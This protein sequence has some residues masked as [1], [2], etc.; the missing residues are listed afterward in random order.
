MIKN[1]NRKATV[2]RTT[3]S[4]KTQKK[5]SANLLLSLLLLPL[6]LL[7]LLVV[8]QNPLQKQEQFK[9]NAQLSSPTEWGEPVRL[10]RPIS[11]WGWDDMPFI[12]ASGDK[13]YLVSNPCGCGDTAG[14]P[15]Y[16]P[17]N[18]QIFA[19]Y[20]ANMGATSWE[21]PQLLDTTNINDPTF[22]V[23]AQYITPDEQTIYFSRVNW[24]V[25]KDNSLDLYV[26][27]KQPD[28]TWGPETRLPT[29]INTQVQED[30]P[31]L[32]LD[33]KELYFWRP[34]RVGGPKIYVSKRD[35]IN[36]DTC[37]GNPQAL[38]S[39][40]NSGFAWHPFIWYDGR[41]LYFARQ[42]RDPFSCGNTDHVGE[43]L[44]VS[45]RNDNGTWTDPQRLNFQRTAGSE[46]DPCVRQNYW[47][48]AGGPSVT[49]DGQSLYFVLARVN[50][51]NL[52]EYRCVSKVSNDG[53]CDYNN[54]MSARLD[55]WTVTSRPPTPTLTPTP[56]FIP[57]P[58]QPADTVAPA[59]SITY[60][61]DGSTVP[62]NST[63]TITADASDNIG[64]TRVELY[65]NSVLK[66]T[67]TAS[68]YSCNWKVPGATGRAYAL[69]ARAYD[70]AGNIGLSS[71][72]NVTSR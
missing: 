51:D 33:G 49:Q 39:N 12:N 27:H 31:S 68:P 41:T 61:T 32:S 58:T 38:P 48:S 10:D 15:D 2:T 47:Q 1:K 25:L 55:V 53:E 72:I 26:S 30:G 16:R 7:G 65:V 67:D 69:Q 45:Q 18:W 50:L 14:L 63:V 59:V 60:P 56:T 3:A 21:E 44:F 5:T 40:I 64:V 4:R 19:S 34:S 28:G 57:T 6:L 23:G 46:S 71:I 37:W 66:C 29:T 70:A 11:Y 62:R 20:V 42:I 36:C 54:P 8:N 13:L 24:S 17:G 9:V 52:G 43:A 22:G 35:D